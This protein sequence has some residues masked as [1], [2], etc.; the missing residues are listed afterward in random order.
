MTYTIKLP[1]FEGPFDLLLH[2]IKVNEM[3]IAD[4]PISEITKQYLSYI[5][6]MRELDLELAGDFLVMAATLI[7][8]KA[9]TLMPVPPDLEEQEEEISEI[10]SARELMRQLVEYRKYKE[11]ASALREREEQAAR[12][13]FRN[14]TFT[15]VPD[16]DGAEIS[17]DIA[18]LY[19]AFARVLKFVDQ[20][21]YKPGISE[22]FTVEDKINHI[23][24]L[25]R[26]NETVD[27]M[28]VFEHCLNRAE[29]IVTFLAVLELCRMKR[30]LIRQDAAFDNVII[31]A[32]EGQLEY[33]TEHPHSEP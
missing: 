1:V 27:L 4:I 25:T 18:L 11:A 14:S 7:H 30:I 21:A 12:V 16:D 22:R 31:T 23:E 19:K 10:M 13:L 17:V 9:R 3:D 6:V 20:P 28:R 5:D 15:L 2:L 26:S 33:D 24:D 8:L 32:A 29:I